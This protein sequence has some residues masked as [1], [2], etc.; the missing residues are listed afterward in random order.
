M[1]ECVGL[2]IDQFGMWEA[3]PNEWAYSGYTVG[4]TYILYTSPSRVILF[5]F[6]IKNVE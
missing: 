5:L 3:H 4:I 1:C 2:M 6:A